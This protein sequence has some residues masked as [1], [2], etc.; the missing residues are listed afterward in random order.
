MFKTG[1]GDDD[2]IAYYLRVYPEQV[3]N[4]RIII[5]GNHDKQGWV[6]GCPLLKGSAFDIFIVIGKEGYVV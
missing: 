3:S 4:Q 5:D 6:F 1:K 2:D